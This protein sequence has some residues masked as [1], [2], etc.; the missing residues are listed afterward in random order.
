MLSFKDATLADALSRGLRSV[1]E[2]RETKKWIIY[3]AKIS[4][5][6]KEKAREGGQ[7]GRWEVSG[8]GRLFREDL[9]DVAT[10]EQSPE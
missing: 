2:Q 1:E 9:P 10:E 7:E 5:V 6:E 3:K 8:G 4:A